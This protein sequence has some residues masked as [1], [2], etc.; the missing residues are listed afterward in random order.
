[1]RTTVGRARAP[2]CSAAQVS[3][4]WCHV[5]T[6]FLYA[7]PILVTSQQ[8]R[9]FRQRIT[10]SPTLARFVR[11]PTILVTSRAGP[12]FENPFRELFT[13]RALL[14]REKEAVGDVSIILGTCPSLDSI[15]V[16][17][18]LASEYRA[19]DWEI[20]QTKPARSH[21]SPSHRDIPNA[22]GSGGLKKL[23]IFRNNLVSNRNPSASL[24]GLQVLCLNLSAM[25]IPFEFPSFPNLHTIQIYS[26]GIWMTH[27][28]GANYFPKAKFPALRSVLLH[29]NRIAQRHIIDLVSPQQIQ[30]LDLIGQDEVKAFKLLTEPLSTNGTSDHDANANR[31]STTTTTKTALHPV[32]HLTLGNLL[33]ADHAMGRWNLTETLESLTLFIEP[34]AN[35]ASLDVLS[36]FLDLNASKIRSGSTALRTIT[37]NV[38][39]GTGLKL[40][41]VGSCTSERDLEARLSEIKLAVFNLGLNFKQ[42]FVGAYLVLFCAYSMEFGS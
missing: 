3:R 22:S 13:Q 41:D 15:A 14:R 34:D 17:L 19:Y 11:A 18:P 21:A 10:S 20:V 42:D 30:N 24:A 8:L 4:A 25:A 36:K 1:M 6:P 37:V 9:T 26:N 31:E 12:D 16:Q 5:C 35:S 23:T 29:Q 28:A 27:V 33:D 32:K 39:V 2:L 40:L 7:H 38:N